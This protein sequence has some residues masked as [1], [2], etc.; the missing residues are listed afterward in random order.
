MESVLTF[1]TDESVVKGQV[2]IYGGL[3]LSEPSLIELSRYIYDLKDSYSL[4]QELEIKWRYETYWQ[5]MVQIGY[6]DKS[7]TRKTKPGLYKSIKEDHKN[8]KQ[9]ILNK[10]ANADLQ[11]V[12]CIRP[13]ELLG[14][15]TEQKVK[16]P[17]ADVARKFEKV[18]DARDEYGIIFADEL[19]KKI[20]SDDVIDHQYILQLCLRRGRIISIVPTVNSKISPVHQINDVV[21]GCINFYILEFIRR[22][23]D[24]NRDCS[25]A[26][27][28][29]KMI[30]PKFLTSADG[31]HVINSGI[32]LYPP[33]N[34]RS[35]T[36]AGN[37]LD[38][39]ERQL[40]AD[41]AII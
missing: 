37:F 9:K 33:K 26:I 12:V 8:L 2:S 7:F 27:N 35:N 24:P 30:Q 19:Q 17:I 31:V 1:F 10:V 16:Y 20:R 40:Q 36:P 5:N 34:S 28:L 32:L 6:L 4:S 13:D 3:I 41:F 23:A 38:N 29:L 14:A 22:N 15:T 39:L 11:I 25:T 18:L 21:L